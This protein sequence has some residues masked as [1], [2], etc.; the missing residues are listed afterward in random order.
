LSSAWIMVRLPTG[1]A[2][3]SRN[4]L[5]SSLARTNTAR[6]SIV[7]LWP[8][9][10]IFVFG[11]ASAVSFGGLLSRHLYSWLAV[12]RSRWRF[13]VS[14]LTSGSATGGARKI[15]T[16]TIGLTTGWSPVL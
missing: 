7:A 15:S 1:Q 4:F 10:V 5:R 3:P 8:R 16:E 11:F 12:E 14:V 6:F 2:S 9:T 13:L